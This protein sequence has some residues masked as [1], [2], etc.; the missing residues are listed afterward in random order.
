M[1]DALEAVFRN[2]KHTHMVLFFI[3]LMME[4]NW[5]RWSGGDM[6]CQLLTLLRLSPLLSRVFTFLPEGLYLGFLIFANLGQKCSGVDFFWDKNVLG[7]AFIGHHF[8]YRVRALWGSDILNELMIKINSPVK[9]YIFICIITVL[10][11][12]MFPF[13]QAAKRNSVAYLSLFNY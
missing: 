10:H 12:V 5:S 8:R 9:L 3:L 11:Y 6:R 13:I 2:N 7:Q 4:I 1:N